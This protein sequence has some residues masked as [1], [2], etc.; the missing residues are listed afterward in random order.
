MEERQKIAMEIL[1]TERTYVERLTIL[2]EQFRDPLAAKVG[3]PGQI[4]TDAAIQEI[5]KHLEPILHFHRE[6]LQRLESRIN[7]PSWNPV[8]GC[9]GD[10][11]IRLAPYLKIYTMYLG[12]CS[13]AMGRVSAHMGASPAFVRFL[14]EVD[15]KQR[16]PGITLQAYLLEPMQRVPRYCLLLERLMRKTGIG[17]PDHEQLKDALEEVEKVT[18]FANEML[19]GHDEARRIIDI[20][21]SLAGF[22]ERLLVPGRKLLK[23]GSVRKICRKN[24][25]RREFFLFSDILLYASPGIIEDSFVFHRKLL[26]E[27]CKVVSVTDNEMVQNAFQILSPDKSFQVYTESP[28]EKREWID[29]ISTAIQEL[30]EAQGTLK[31]EKK[32]RPQLDSFKHRVV[33][34]YKAPVWVPDDDAVCCMICDLEFRLYRRKHHCRLCGKVVCHA[35]SSRNFLIPGESAEQDRVER[36][37]DLCFHERWG[38]A[39]VDDEEEE[40]LAD[41]WRS[42]TLNFV[43]SPG[44]AAR[45]GRVSVNTCTRTHVS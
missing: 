6:L 42:R 5:F 45:I 12:N 30:Q 44:L 11:F 37:C 24:H 18:K 13:H 38:N 14:K 25:Q 2:L 36:A 20:Q 15:M 39:D 7:V 27:H 16:M 3:K 40:A 32:A 35:C 31:K 41:L 34:E 22:S 4:L 43:Q 28:Q 23:R 26:L 17:H 8:Q 21:R 9:L 1:D 33:D 10:I 29:A 19:R